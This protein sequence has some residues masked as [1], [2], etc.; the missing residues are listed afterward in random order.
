LASATL[1]IQTIAYEADGARMIGYFAVDGARPQRRPGVLIAHSGPGLGEHA[2][3]RARKVAALGYAVFAMDY[4]GGG[5]TLPPGE[6]VR[7][8]I[9]QYLAT[10][11]IRVRARA[12][13]GVLTAQP[14]TDPDQLAAI[15]YCFGGTTVLELARDGAPLKAV[16]GFHS[17]LE[18]PRPQDAANI[19]GK[20]VV[21]LGSEDP[22][23][24]P[25]QRLAFEE[26]MR[27][28]GVDWQ[29]HLCGGARHSFT[30]PGIDAIANDAGIDALRYHRPS[31]ERSWRLMLD[32]L[33][34]TFGPNI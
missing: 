34:E 17:G 19:V 16:F 8:R 11:G 2:K 4:H 25:Q 26:E 9:S 7:V 21:C 32:L 13:L 1:R 18:T 29:L 31:D 22:I 15:G 5:I 24:P 33:T 30:D 20:V 28:G 6:E 23:I 12:A 3:G 10:G 27:A 14:E